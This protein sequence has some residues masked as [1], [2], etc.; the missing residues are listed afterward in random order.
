M[1]CTA[2][3]ES[4]ERCTVITSVLRKVDDSA[5][6]KAL[7]PINW[8]VVTVV[9]VQAS[10]GGKMLSIIFS[11]CFFP[12]DSTYGYK[13][14]MGDPA[15]SNVRR[16]NKK[17]RCRSRKVEVAEATKSKSSSKKSGAGG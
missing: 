13:K 1:Q 14:S 16:G 3:K 5:K 2:W 15:G 17:Y 12:V 10:K 9:T 11:Q 7:S 6:W 4:T 8:F